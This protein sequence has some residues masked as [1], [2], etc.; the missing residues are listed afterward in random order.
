MDR[1]LAGYLGGV[2]AKTEYD[3]LRTAHSLISDEEDGSQ[4]GKR[5]R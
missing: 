5:Y 2:A 3:Q 1:D 4:V